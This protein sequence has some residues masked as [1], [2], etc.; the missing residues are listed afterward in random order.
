[1]EMKAISPLKRSKAGGRG[2]SL[3]EAVFAMVILLILAIGGMSFV[4]HGTNGLN[5]YSNKM[6]ALEIANNRLE[7]L[8][9]FNYSK[10]TAN[11]P[12]D[13][14]TRYIK[15]Q[16]SSWYADGSGNLL[17][18]GSDQGET[19]NINGINE[20]VSTTVQYQDKGGDATASYDYLLII[21]KA[22]YHPNSSERVEL[23]T[24]VGQYK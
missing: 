3:V 4:I 10:L 6:I 15:K 1:M 7:E 24:Y 11:A 16:G 21:T 2:A 14:S 13:Y 9:A 19:V 12:N 5:I 17:L 22:G 20:P 8:R 18:Y 23:R